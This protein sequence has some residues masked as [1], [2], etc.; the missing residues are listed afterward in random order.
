MDRTHL[1]V[2]S[3]KKNDTHPAT[4]LS[5]AAARRRLSGTATSPSSILY[6]LPRTSAATTDASAATSSPGSAVAT[7][8]NGKALRSPHYLPELLFTVEETR[9]GEGSGSISGSSNVNGAGTATTAGHTSAGQYSAERRSS[10]PGA[11]TT[12]PTTLPEG[13]SKA[14]PT[15]RAHAR[16]LSPLSPLALPSSSAASTPTTTTTPNSATM[17]GAT[18]AALKSPKACGAAP[19]L[20]HHDSARPTLVSAS[21]VTAAAAAAAASAY[22][23]PRVFSGNVPRA[24]S[25]KVATF[26]QRRIPLPPPTVVA[27]GN[28]DV[29]HGCGNT[30]NA[31]LS[32]HGL[33]VNPLH[34]KSITVAATTSPATAAAT[35]A[36]AAA[37]AAA[38]SPTRIGSGG[39]TAAHPGTAD[40]RLQ[41]TR[42]APAPPVPLAVTRSTSASSVASSLQS[43][44][45][46]SDSQPHS[47]A[48]PLSLV[49][50][51]AVAG[52][53]G[54]L[55]APVSF[56]SAAR[57]ER[58]GSGEAA[59]VRAPTS[60]R[61]RGSAPL[62]PPLP[63]MPPT[64][65]SS[66]SSSAGAEGKKTD[67]A[68]REQA[69]M[70]RDLLHYRR[71][72]Q[73][74]G[75][76]M[77]TRNR[78]DLRYGVQ[79]VTVQ[80]SRPAHMLGNEQM[81]FNVEDV[82]G[83][84]IE[85]D[86]N[87]NMSG[88]RANS[89]ITA[90][91][92]TTSAA[93]AAAAVA[94]TKPRSTTGEMD[95]TVSAIEIVTTATAAETT[96]VLRRANA[97]A[98]HGSHNSMEGAASRQHDGSFAQIKDVPPSQQ[99][100]HSH[101]HHSRHASSRSHPSILS[102]CSTPEGGNV[103]G[104]GSSSGTGSGVHFRKND[105]SPK[106]GGGAAAGLRRSLPSDRL[107]ARPSSTSLTMDAHREGSGWSRGEAGP[108]GGSSRH[109][110][111]STLTISCAP[112][113][114][115]FST[116]SDS[117]LFP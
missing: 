45:G 32:S 71:C 105:A 1:M 26:E 70:V 96:A 117:S 95:G 103:E 16:R 99:Q 29:H 39:R 50:P 94:A 52:R 20:P 79:P 92:L 18:A 97:T 42:G 100:Q 4:F 108:W 44:G 75:L 81:F 111:L 38:S 14:T 2:D 33:G 17:P 107:F 62:P 102:R 66:A 68:D 110:N 98:S 8:L 112:A 13:K 30:V 51:A 37:A 34:A 114:G 72:G 19:A 91:I 10:S 85:E 48:S 27:N 115:S 3:N 41:V 60:L 80:P 67:L 69:Q 73:H 43:R 93:T 31:H 22:A 21:A 89:D 6:P 57:E 5:N 109:M 12:P 47:P 86:D 7:P 53:R 59:N 46:D 9:D 78:D 90:G 36:A 49:S 63:P 15:L 83:E 24:N 23:A 35:V 28:N 64:P 82:D 88:N 113:L 106:H 55:F 25:A 40:T 65:P 84:E 54:T 11:V 101:S 58:P 76:L 77:R 116:N 61:S 87:N 56:G 104:G 74:R